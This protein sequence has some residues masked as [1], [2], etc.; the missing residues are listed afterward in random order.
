ML[1]R[2]AG[3]SSIAISQRYVYLFRGCGSVCD[4]SLLWAQFLDTLEKRY[5][6]NER[7]SRLELIL[8]DWV[9]WCAE[10][11]ELQFPNLT[12]DEESIT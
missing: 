8:I 11:I 9:V 4:V 3:H 12:S 7:S 2:I 1:A 6:Q 5:F 10:G